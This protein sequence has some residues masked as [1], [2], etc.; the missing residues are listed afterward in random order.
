MEDLDRS[1]YVV[2]G[3]GF[4]GAVVVVV[5]DVGG[6]RCGMVSGGEVSVHAVDVVGHVVFLCFVVGVENS[7]VGC[8]C[9]WWLPYKMPISGSVT[10]G[11]VADGYIRLSSG[12]GVSNQSGC[13]AFASGGQVVG[14]SR[15]SQRG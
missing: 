11:V 4:G 12:S 10:W 6:A 3:H 14:A 15:S 9:W 7:V 13:L 8:C 1:R 5:G 2:D